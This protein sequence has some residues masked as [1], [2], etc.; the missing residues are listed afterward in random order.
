MVRMANSF[1]LISVMLLMIAVVS[2]LC[3]TVAEAGTLTIS[4]RKVTAGN[5][6]NFMTGLGV[7]CKCCDGEGANGSV[8]WQAL[9][10]VV[11]LVYRVPVLVESYPMQSLQ[12]DGCM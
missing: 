4:H 7:M 3:P 8:I 12:V 11:S 1:K 10:D 9:Y 5:S 6:K 2:S